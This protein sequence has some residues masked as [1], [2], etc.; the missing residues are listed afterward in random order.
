VLKPEGLLVCTFIHSSGS[1]EHLQNGWVYPKCIGYKD[2]TVSDF[3]LK[4]GLFHQ[5]IPWYH[6]RQIWYIASKSI[7]KN[8]P[9]E[10]LHQL[11]GS[12]FFDPVFKGSLK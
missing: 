2:D 4:A 8:I 7:N 9:S 5:Q 3:M 11:G 10:R 1:E 6:P 12:V